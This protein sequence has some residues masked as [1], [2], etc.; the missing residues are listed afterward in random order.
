MKILTVT[1]E[2]ATDKRYGLGKSLAPLVQS[3]SDQGIAHRY[4]CQEDLGH[5]ASRLPQSVK[6]FIDKIMRPFKP[7]SDLSTLAAIILERINM[8]RLAAKVAAQEQYTHVHC[9]DP[10]IGAGFRFFA[11]ITPKCRARWGVTQHGFGCYTQAIIDENIHISPLVNH[12]MRRW[13]ARTLHAANWLISPTQ[14]SLQQ[15]AR[16]LS[17]GQLPA[18]WHAIV[19][20]KPSITHWTSQNARRELG[21]SETEQVVLAVGRLIPL[22]RFDLMI[23]AIAKIPNVRLVILGE[24]PQQALLDLAE[25]RGCGERVSI[26][27]TDDIGLYLHAC[28]IY[29]STS[30]TESFGI[31][32]LEAMIA[33]TPTICTAVGGVPDVVAGGAQLIAVDNVAVLTETLQSLLQHPGQQLLW[34]AKALARANAWPDSTALAQQHLELY[35]TG[36]INALPAPQTLPPTLLSDVSPAHRWAEQLQPCPLPKVLPIDNQEGL[37]VLVFAPHPDDET[38]GCGGTLAR[39]KQ[40]GA[41]IR[42]VL[43]SLGEKGYPQGFDPSKAGATRQQEFLQAMSVLGI[44]DVTFYHQ[45]DAQITHSPAL[46]EHLIEEFEDYQP[47]W[48]YL[49]SPLD[50]HRDH[51]TV[52]LSILSVWERLGYR[53]RTWLYEVW[54]P[55]PVTHVVDITQINALKKEALLHYVLPLQCLDYLHHMHG[56]NSYRGLALGQDQAIAEGFTEVEASNWQSLIASLLDL[57]NRQEH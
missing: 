51:A 29:V 26:T 25:Q 13:E 4:L 48:L 15:L 21:W 16:D 23:E 1:R 34:S 28:D 41:Q 57:R 19:H 7:S 10:I 22:K 44:D 6:K 40:A 36:E 45:P 31:A 50:C 2:W 17:L 20:P 43:V 38:L 39:L 32:N 9:H 47:Q 55:L 14:A 11:R 35:Q 3:F 46:V 30:Q 24:G 12:W 56:L 37:K 8:G 52:S 27:L 42:V 33:A 54:T 18:H 53:Q 5:T 49:P